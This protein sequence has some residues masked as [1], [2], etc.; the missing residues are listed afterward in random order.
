MPNMATRVV[1][2]TGSITIA[3]DIYAR[4]T[5]L[6]SSTQIPKIIISAAG[7]IRINCNVSRIDAILISGGTVHTCNGYSSETQ[8]ALNSRE[9]SLSQL[10]INGVIIANTIN[11]ART[12]GNAIGN[13]S[14]TPAEIINY[15]TSSLIWAHSMAEASE[16]SVMTTVYQH[17]LAPRY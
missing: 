8:N 4:S 6:T 15:D 9:R 14:G 11:P 5:N 12:Y 1:K 17:E 2:A 16:S 10:V 3:G 7:D 13:Q